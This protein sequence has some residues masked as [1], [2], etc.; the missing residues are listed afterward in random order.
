MGT[1]VIAAIIVQLVLRRGIRSDYRH[2]SVT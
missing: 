2:D 1:S